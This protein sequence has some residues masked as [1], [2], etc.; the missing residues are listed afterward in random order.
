MK[1]SEEWKALQAATLAKFRAM[2]YESLA[3]KVDTCEME[4]SVG[5]SGTKYSVQVSVFWDGRT[6]GD[7]RVICAVDDGGLSAI[8]P[9]SD[10]FI[11][12]PDGSFVGE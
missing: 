12:A 5:A 2:T 1:P 7:V 4:E 6:G 11:M 10:D 9:K 3:S 8:F